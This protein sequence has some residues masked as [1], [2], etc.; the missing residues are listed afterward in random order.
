MLYRGSGAAM[1]PLLGG[2]SLLDFA[3]AANATYDDQPATW[4]SPRGDVHSYLSR[5]GSLFVVSQEGTQSGLEWLDDFD[6]FPVELTGV[7][8]AGPVHQGIRDTMLEVFP[9]IRGYLASINWPPFVLGGHSKGAGEVCE[10]AALFKS[11]GHAPQAVAAFEPPMVGTAKLRAYLAD[12]PFIVTQTKNAEG[13]DIVTEAC[14]IFV[15]ACHVVEPMQLIVPDTL[16]IRSK[17]L[18]PAVLVAIQ[19]LGA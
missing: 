2:A 16:D 17:H 19:G 1:I 5:I 6:A 9:Q 10:M 4:T 13:V 7:P 15:E 11:I 8:E 3:V 12:V 18:M 14:E